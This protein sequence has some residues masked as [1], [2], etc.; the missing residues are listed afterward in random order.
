MNARVLPVPVGESNKVLSCAVMPAKAS[1][2]IAFNLTT[3]MALSVFSNFI[4]IFKGKEI[5]TEV[6]HHLTFIKKM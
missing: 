6:A 4:F 1:S 3:P 2:C 5:S